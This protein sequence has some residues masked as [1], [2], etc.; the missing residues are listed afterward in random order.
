MKKITCI[1]SVIAALAFVPASF[2]QAKKKAPEAAPA[3]AKAGD[4][5]VPAGKAPAAEVKPKA[6]KPLPFSA[7]AD[8]IDAAGKTFTHN[9]ADGKKVKFVVTDKTE[10]KQGDLAAKFEDIKVGDVVDGLRVK[11]SADGT[12]YEVIKITKFAAKPV[13]PAKPEGKPAKADKKA[14]AKPEAKPD[15]KK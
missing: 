12:E 3:E 9:N 6:A 4:A 11:K 14:D 10:L 5:K 1:L 8:E 2:A 7:S 15:A 13:K